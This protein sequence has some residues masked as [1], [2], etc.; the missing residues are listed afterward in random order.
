MTGQHQLCL[1]NSFVFVIKHLKK[2]FFLI[3]IISCS[4]GSEKLLG[5]CI[6]AP[7]PDTICTEEYNPV[8][9]CNNVVYSNSCK[10]EK[11]GN[12]KWK[13]TNKDTGDQCSYD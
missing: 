13:Y 5:D 11:A 10:A 12:L 2:L 6:V 7:S 1:L 3:F 9:A 8:C 4:S